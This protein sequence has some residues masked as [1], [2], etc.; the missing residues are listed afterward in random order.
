M[1]AGLLTEL[2]EVLSS[3]ITTNDYGEETTEWESTYTTRAR[4]VHNGGGR[5]SENDEVFYASMKVFQVRLYVPINEY[6][7]IKWNGNVYRV[8]DIEPDKAQQQLTI[9]AELIND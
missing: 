1:R 8:L 7:R 9:K 2:V 3:V 5:T 6:C 4:L